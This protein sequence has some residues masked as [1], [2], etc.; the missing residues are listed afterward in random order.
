MRLLLL[1]TISLLSTA[2]SN[3]DSYNRGYVISQSH[4]EAVVDVTTPPSE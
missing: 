1:L 3:G 2:C 4:E